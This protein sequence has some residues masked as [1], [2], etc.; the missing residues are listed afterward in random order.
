[1]FEP[2]PLF[3]LRGYM[4]LVVIY[5]DVKSLSLFVPKFPSELCS[6]NGYWHWFPKLLSDNHQEFVSSILTAGE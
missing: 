1:M 2:R 3:Y 4:I 6:S 5:S